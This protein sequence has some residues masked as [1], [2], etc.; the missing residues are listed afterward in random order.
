MH[1][2]IEFFDRNFRHLFPTLTSPSKRAYVYVN[3]NIDRRIAFFKAKKKNM[4]V[5]QKFR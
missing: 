4:C 1:N 2:R 5:H 3:V